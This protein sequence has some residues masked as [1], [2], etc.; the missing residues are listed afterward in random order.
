MPVTT[1]AN[2]DARADDHELAVAGIVVTSPAHPGRGR[3]LGTGEAGLTWKSDYR[4]PAAADPLT[5]ADV[6]IAVLSEGHRRRVRAARRAGARRCRAGERPVSG[7]AARQAAGDA[8]RRAVPGVK[9]EI[10]AA[11]ERMRGLGF[12][13]DQIAAELARG[14]KLRPRRAYRIAYGWTQTEAAARPNVRA[15]EQA[16]GPNGQAILTAAHL[17]EHEGWPYL[18]IEGSGLQPAASTAPDSRHG[19]ALRLIAPPHDAAGAAK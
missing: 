5:T 13:C 18:V 14:Y 10:D 1:A 15:A 3:V 17:S 4:T 11:R 9:A 8:G 16:T 19:H 2:L 7:A 12:G 6:I